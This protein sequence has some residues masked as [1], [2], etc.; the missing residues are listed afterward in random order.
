M[1]N[2]KRRGGRTFLIIGA[3]LI[4]LSAFGL[5]SIFFFHDLFRFTSSNSAIYVLSGE[6]GGV[7]VRR[8][9]L[10]EEEDRLIFM[11]D[12][13]CVFNIFMRNFAAFAKRPMLELT[14][15]EETGQ[16]VI[17]KFGADGSIIEVTFS[18]FRDVGKPLGLFIG[19]DL[20]YGDISRDKHHATSGMAY[21]DGKKWV[22]LWCAANEGFSL[23]G[24][25]EVL[26]PEKWK[27]LGAKIIKDTYDEAGIESFHEVKTGGRTVLMTRRVFFRA[28]DDYL[29]LEIKIANPNTEPIAYTYVYG[30]EP[31]VGKFGSS[32]GDVGWYE[33]GL[34]DRETAIDPK[35]YKYAGYWDHGNEYA[36]QGRSYS[37]YANFISWLTPAPDT[38]YLANE[39]ECCDNDRPLDSSHKRVIGIAWYAEKLM[40]GESRTHVLVMGKADIRGDRPTMPKINLN[41]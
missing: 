37:G 29:T 10:A 33:G 34:I 4:F 19:G 14:W 18:R 25:E 12:A 28:P 1:E 39:F 20:P 22:H 16:G 11:L 8:D 27:Y 30:D 17:K 7:E 15:W 31:W 2:G 36:G 9:M 6:N 26:S 32:S 5:T 41:Y 24:T 35:R 3:V 23:Y 21:Y 13:N 38:V 40:P